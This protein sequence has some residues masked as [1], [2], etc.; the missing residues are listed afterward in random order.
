MGKCET[1]LEKT[2]KETT[3]WEDF[4]NVMCFGG[5]NSDY[6][7]NMPFCYFCKKETCGDCMAEKPRLL[8]QFM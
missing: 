1:I 4:K 2:R 3:W 8:P 5:E 7:G 6:S